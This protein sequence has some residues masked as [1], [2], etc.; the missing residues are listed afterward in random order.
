MHAEAS[1]FSRKP[2]PF[3]AIFPTTDRRVDRNSVG[4][5]SLARD[6]SRILCPRV[7]SGTAGDECRAYG[8]GLEL[9]AKSVVCS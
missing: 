8:D 4:T 2:V 9:E 1:P 7:R 6:L 5:G 3:I